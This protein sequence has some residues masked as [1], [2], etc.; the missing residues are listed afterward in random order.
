M[1]ITAIIIRNDRMTS[2][3]DKLYSNFITKKKSFRCSTAA[4]MGVLGSN[5]R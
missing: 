5:K 4:K 3:M 2:A 1:I